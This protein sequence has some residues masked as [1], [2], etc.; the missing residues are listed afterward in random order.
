VKRWQ[1]AN[2]PLAGRHLIEAS[3]GTGKTHTI[4][5]LFVRLLVEKEL[6]VDKILV[7]TYTNAA[8]AELRSRIRNRLNEIASY[9][10][11][12]K[13]S[14]DPELVEWLRKRAEGGYRQRD[15]ARV[16]QALYAYD[17]AAIF[18]IHGFCQRVLS[19]YALETGNR[20]DARLTT[21]PSALLWEA[22]Y[23]FWAERVAV[24]P[25]LFMSYAVLG[26][27][28]PR[29]SPDLLMALAREFLAKSPAAVLPEVDAPPLDSALER[30]RS[31]RER[32]RSCWDAERALIIEQ[33]CDK[34]SL[35]QTKYRPDRIRDSWAPQ[36]ERFFSEE[37]ALLEGAVDA[38]ERL[39]RE[40]LQQSIKKGGT[41]PNHRFFSIWSDLVE[42]DRA[43]QKNFD[44][45]RRRLL[46]DWVNGLK[47]RLDEKKE[48][49]GRFSYDDLIGRV[50]DALLGPRGQDLAQRLQRH[51]PAALID[52]FQDTDR[53]QYDIFNQI[54]AGEHPLDASS[55]SEVALFLIG[56]PK[57]A[58]YGFRGADIFA[59]LHAKRAAQKNSYTMDVNWRS[60]P[61]MVGAINYLFESVQN[62][63]MVQNIDFEPCQAA[64][65][66]RPPLTGTL[67]RMA[68]LQIQ[69]VAR[70]E[71]YI[72]KKTKGMTKDWA[73]RHLSQA[74]AAQLSSL[75]GSDMRI[76]ERQFGPS[77]IA[78]LCRT[79]QQV[80]DIEAALQRVG[81]PSVRFGAS[82]VFQSEEADEIER[83]MRAWYDPADAQ[84][85]CTALAGRLVGLNAAQLKSL[86]GEEQGLRH[87]MV[88][89]RR[90][91]AIWFERGFTPAFRAFLQEADRL[92]Q[93]LCV[94]GGERQVTNIL[95]LA[96]LIQ[97]A[98]LESRLGPQGLIYWINAM[99]H[100][101]MVRADM[102]GDD[103]EQRLESD[104]E[105]VRLVTIHGA[106]GLE[107]PVVF[108]PFLW[109][110][111][112]REGDEG[113]W[114][115][116]HQPADAFSLA[117]D[118]GSPEH[119]HHQELAQREEMAESMRLLYVALTRAK[120]HC[121]VIWGALSGWS[122]S[123]LGY[124]LHQSHA[125]DAAADRVAATEAR[126]SQIS[127][128]DM[129]DEL[130]QLAVHSHG[131]IEVSDLAFELG[132]KYT[133]IIPLPGG[134][135]QARPGPRSVTRAWRSASFTALTQGGHRAES[136]PADEAV[137]PERNQSVSLIDAPDS[138]AVARLPLADFPAGSLPGRAIHQLFE[139]L[140]FADATEQ[141]V[142]PLA[143]ETV[144]SLGV[145]G[146]W[147]EPL[148]RAVMAIIDT[149]LVHPG[150]D[151]GMQ[152]VESALTRVPA[153]SPPVRLRDITR[154]RRLDELEFTLPVNGYAARAA[155]EG[156]APLLTSARLA[157]TLAMRRQP[158]WSPGYLDRVAALG[159]EPLQGFV[160]GFIDLVFFH[161]ERWY[162]VDYKSNQLGSTADHYG[163]SALVKTMEE[164]HYFLQYHFYLLALDRYLKQRQPDYAYERDF[165][166]VYYLFL[167]GMAPELPA[168]TGI[169]YDRPPA[170]AIEALGRLFPRGEAMR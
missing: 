167:R 109:D 17:Q 156:P 143:I 64:P 110:A 124:L 148:G 8:T 74:V 49:L 11:T 126:L 9:A 34:G 141:T 43:L 106:K 59:Y 90:Y 86:L 145:S 147:A 162:L 33:L 99:R 65:R 131:T 118:L 87:F 129:R 18:T 7:V 57:Q 82:S 37:Y 19:D 15:A 115:V 73:R 98:T 31:Q 54:Y 47:P 149:S 66:A 28:K 160:R 116:F 21:D 32:A 112:W 108:C 26:T 157:E 166:G 36:I 45:L 16:S 58:I 105:A 68:P 159:F 113:D 60:D 152:S 101:A 153:G 56:D 119:T 40:G 135:L 146:E 133:N 70:Q 100:D 142:G 91:Q 81:V 12:D 139:Q 117:L 168:G 69:F 88:Q 46:T 132:E 154:E 38:R 23:D 138:P 6:D 63:F 130:Q 125:P 67:A 2:W 41:V 170:A 22:A 5:T 150:G 122:R 77:D 151:T 97:G 89:F 121:R 52:E 163:T 3:A 25:E 72:D 71:G 107:Y 44:Q 137:E 164:H 30:W 158:V 35:N 51:Y 27:A 79:R 78:V 111:G 128:G 29:L 140:D 61:S 120:H 95:H 104:S 127:D 92:S 24:L 1:S 14:G 161:Q 96:E 103:S 80:A 114:A 55:P 48:Q 84:A 4:V 42:T 20:F 123:P 94:S 76:G 13:E 144:Q 10:T 62:P 93:L 83:L 53:G 165:G 134:A 50:R 169:F 136:D 102:F 39:T 155:P 75:L 85:V